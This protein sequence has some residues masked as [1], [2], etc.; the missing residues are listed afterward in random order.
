MEN[1]EGLIG[2]ITVGVLKAGLKPDTSISMVVRAMHVL[3][4]CLIS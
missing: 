2:S 1:Y 4:T 3:V